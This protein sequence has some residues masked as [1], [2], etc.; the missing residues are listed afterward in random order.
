MGFTTDFLDK[1][2]DTEPS[3][4]LKLK[5]ILKGA[6]RDDSMKRQSIRISVRILSGRESLDPLS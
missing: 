4:G 6:L 5:A 2:Y 3:I 1:N